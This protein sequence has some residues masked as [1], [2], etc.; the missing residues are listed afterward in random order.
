MRK[1][2]LK[3]SNYIYKR[4]FKQN[5]SENEEKFILNVSWVSLGV[6]IAKIMMYVI[7]ALAGRFLGPEIY[8][9]ANLIV[10]IAMFLSIPLTI[11]AGNHGL[12]KYFQESDCEIEKKKFFST[13]TIALFFSGTLFYLLFFF[14]RETLSFSLGISVDL[15]LW[16]II[17][18]FFSILM[19][20]SETALRMLFLFKEMSI[21]ELFSTALATMVFFLLLMQNNSIGLL[22][23][24]L[25]TMRLLYFLGGIKYLIN[26][27]WLKFDMKIFIKTFN[28]NKYIILTNI[29]GVLITNIDKIMLN[30]FFGTSSVGI[31]QAYF[32]SSTVIIGV[33]ITIFVH[34][35]F[36]TIIKIKDK[37]NVLKK[38]DVLLL[39]SVFIIFVV[40]LPVSFI[41]IKYVYGYQILL[42]PLLISVLFSAVL[43][44]QIIQGQYLMS[45]NIEGAKQFFIGS[46]IQS[47]INVILN[48]IFIPLWMVSGA[49]F[50]TFI[51][52]IIGY[53]Y[54]RYYSSKLSQK[55]NE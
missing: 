51:T 45:L 32:F 18:S 38:L 46:L 3:S 21:V 40:M 26:Y 22:I 11:F 28:Y 14:F 53:I 20:F 43:P 25:I 2:I 33:L 19:S 13:N 31:Y 34:V 41:T 47:I 12:I 17:F 15:L 50:A 24:P 52:G 48:I 36:P 49:F 4:L 35:F 8:G 16:A 6:I 39:M 55:L 27:F 23:I 37:I 1:I 5:L 7:H 9:E 10:S 42:F 29:S 44:A 54:F 30:Y